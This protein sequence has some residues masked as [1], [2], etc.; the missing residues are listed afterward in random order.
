MCDHAFGHRFNGS[1]ATGGDARRSKPC[2]ALDGWHK[3]GSA[4]SH[5]HHMIVLT[6]ISTSNP[7][8]AVSATISPTGRK[9]AA[10]R[11]LNDVFMPSAAI[12]A[13]RHQREA[14]LA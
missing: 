13:T 7:I 4:H 2:R 12:A 5:E 6:E 8:Q 10:K 3:C 14:S 1:A 11:S 9:P